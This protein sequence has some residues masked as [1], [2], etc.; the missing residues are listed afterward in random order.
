M[1]A[2]MLL[3]GMPVQVRKRVLVVVAAILVLIGGLAPSAYAHGKHAPK[4]KRTHYRVAKGATQGAKW[5]AP[6]KQR[7]RKGY[8]RTTITGETIYGKP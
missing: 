5:H 6:K 1:S 7:V 4:S 2:E 3:R 8:Y